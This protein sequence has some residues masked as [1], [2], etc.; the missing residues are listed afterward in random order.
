MVSNLNLKKERVHRSTGRS[1]FSEL[2]AF[3]GFRSTLYG[4][5]EGYTVMS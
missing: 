5:K 1:N 3:Q 4:Q 2:L